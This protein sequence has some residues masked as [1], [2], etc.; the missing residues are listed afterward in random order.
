MAKV[1]LI[2]ARKERNMTQ[3]DMAELLFMSQSQYQRREWGEVRISDGEWERMAKFLGKAVEDI[4]E[5]ENITTINNHNNCSG[6]SGYVTGNN[7]FYS[8]PE[9]LMK[10][11]QEYIEALKGEIKRLKEEFS[12]TSNVNKTASS[13]IS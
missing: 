12:R 3:N 5:E 7:Y 11:Q 6:Y 10:N 9:F 8:I 13:N 2:A 4:K 1:K